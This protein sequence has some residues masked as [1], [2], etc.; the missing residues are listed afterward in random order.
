MR[1][2]IWDQ[3]KNITSGEILQALEKD[4]VN[5]WY[6]DETGSSAVVYRND[7]QGRIVSIHNHPHKNFGAKQ[8]KELLKDIGWEENDLKRLKL[9]K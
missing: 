8:L 6:S 2:E 9:I 4:R 5:G 3:L 7:T 1:K